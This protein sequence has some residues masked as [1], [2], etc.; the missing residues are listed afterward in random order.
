MIGVE[1]SVLWGPRDDA[2]TE[3]AGPLRAEQPFD[4]TARDQPPFDATAPPPE[5]P[6]SNRVPAES[7]AA[8]AARKGTAAPASR[9]SQALEAA[10]IR[11][12]FRP[13]P[14]GSST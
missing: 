3:G 6:A 10:T 11:T 2:P 5:A 4:A 12:A 9:P 8:A 14:R 1:R 13:S 7:P